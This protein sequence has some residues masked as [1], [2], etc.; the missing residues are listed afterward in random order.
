[1]RSW[2]FP[3]IDVQPLNESIRFQPKAFFSHQR[4]SVF[5]RRRI[6]SSAGD[7]F[8]AKEHVAIELEVA[9]SVKANELLRLID[10]DAIEPKRIESLSFNRDE[11]S[12]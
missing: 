1:M 10:N 12:V 6:T 9:F 5:V 7:V 11:H 8:F 2:L 3:R 4:L